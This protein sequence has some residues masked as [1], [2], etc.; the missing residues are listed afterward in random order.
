MRKIKFDFNSLKSNTYTRIYFFA[1]I[2]TVVLFAFVLI[3][4][5][6]YAN[7]SK[8]LITDNYISVMKSAFDESEYIFESILEQTDRLI[9]DEIFMSM[10]LRN[11]S[12][13]AV[14]N[15][16]VAYTVS[17][18]L[19]FKKKYTFID[20]IALLNRS[21]DF[22]LFDG[23]KYSLIRYLYDAYKYDNYSY[24]YWM[25]YDTHHQFYN[26]LAPSEVTKWKINDYVVPIVF[27]SI[28]D[29]DTSNVFIVNIRV[30]S[31]FE[32]VVNKLPNTQS[33][34]Y[35]TNNSMKQIFGKKG[36]E[37][38]ML[39]ND[40]LFENILAHEINTF[41][42][43][44][45]NDEPILAISY[46]P[47][48]AMLGFS[49]V[50]AIP[51]THISQNQTFIFWLIFMV[52][53]YIF[54]T[55]YLSNRA[56]NI[57]R[58]IEDI[59]NLFKYENNSQGGNDLIKYIYDSILDKLRKSDDL[60]QELS[61]ALPLMCDRYL[62]NILNGNENCNDHDVKSYLYEKGYINFDKDYFLSIIVRM[63]LTN[64][65][66]ESFNNQQYRLVHNG[67]Y[68]VLQTLFESKYNTYVLANEKDTFYV[69]CNLDNDGDTDS[70][71]KELHYLISLFE[72]DKDY[73]QLN[74]GV[75][76][77]HGGTAGLNESHKEAQS[78][79]IIATGL[80]DVNINVYEPVN[81]K[82]SYILTDKD[83]NHF[84][85]YLISGLCSEAKKLVQ[86]VTD[87]N[88]S[89]NVSKRSIDKL[90]SQFV[91][92]IVKVIKVKDMPFD[93]NEIGDFNLNMQIRPI[94]KS[95]E[96]IM[97]L[98][99]S[100]SEYINQY[101]NEG[102]LEEIIEYINKHACEELYLE[103]LAEI[104]QINAKVLSK[105]IKNYTGISFVDYLAATRVD[106]VKALLETTEKSMA[107]IAEETGFNSRV[108]FIRVFKKLTGLTP[109]KYRAV[110]KKK[111]G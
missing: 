100:I 16:Q 99:D 9:Q 6:F 106:I 7:V 14:S 86:E 105:S 43:K 110:H 1:F 78:A 104:F 32:S 103:K 41:K 77:I 71:V 80:K 90:Y 63:E 10:F 102:R 47:S 28:G 52:L 111:D 64:S 2:P 19:E 13:E 98:I 72:R 29:I 68:Q 81:E 36:S 65:F 109:S 23:G 108:T 51:Y 79:I 69:L 74:I 88:L 11:E 54:I 92:I 84:Y 35:I 73:M 42:W 53:F 40:T 30:Q 95:F 55:F 25:N 96:Y 34:M 3:Q 33:A 26:M 5:I 12:S 39:T 57:V 46:S 85:N 89:S 87:Q 70:I 67:V 20:S 48:R 18:F 8:K 61:V 50:A 91:N 107:S 22:V 59:A 101:N 37:T 60:K 24:D 94:N 21:E 82:I 4:N 66:Y 76:R 31:I 45:N 62:L 17:L 93:G 83:E 97:S 38:D 58:P 75:G 56:K 49:Y 44:N 27:T 15:E